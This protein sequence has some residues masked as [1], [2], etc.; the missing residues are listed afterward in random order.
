MSVAEKSR[1]QFPEKTKQKN[2][3]GS[4]S[5][6]SKQIAPLPRTTIISLAFLWTVYQ[7]ALSACI[8]LWNFSF[9]TIHLFYSA[10]YYNLYICKRTNKHRVIPNHHHL[11]SP[12]STCFT[13]CFIV[14]TLHLSQLALPAVSYSSPITSLSLLYLLFHSLHPSP[15][16]TCFTCCFIVFTLHLSQ[17]ALP[18]VSYS[19]PITSLNNLITCCFILI[20]FPLILWQLWLRGCQNPI[21]N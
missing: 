19:S 4:F 13:C 5:L 2:D 3:T 7:L 16:S 1:R 18:A 14:F 10:L 17:L 8:I 12:L 6:A 21:A 9:A 11:S 20:Q 15:L